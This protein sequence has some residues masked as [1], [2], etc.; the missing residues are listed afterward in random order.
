MC[1]L[2]VCRRT[3]THTLSLHLSLTAAAGEHDEF[4]K[5]NSLKLA[6]ER[7]T[8]LLFDTMTHEKWKK[9]LRFEMWICKSVVYKPLP[10]T[11]GQKSNYNTL[12]QKDKLLHL[13]SHLW[14]LTKTCFALSPLVIR[15]LFS[16]VAEK[17]RVSFAL[18]VYVGKIARNINRR[19]VHK[20]NNKK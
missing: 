6:R 19:Y 13:N 12:R 11:F 7:E 1:V 10:T 15:L 5:W 16:L 2:H 9:N 8:R 18:L 3:N 17:S 14:I 20:G 4:C